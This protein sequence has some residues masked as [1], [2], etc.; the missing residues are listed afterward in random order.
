MALYIWGER[1]RGEEDCVVLSG[2]F[3]F[4]F[5]SARNCP[6]LEI[7]KVLSDT[8]TESLHYHRYLGTVAG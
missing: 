3:V 1:E 4:L 7:R 8:L 2:S 6:K 5:L